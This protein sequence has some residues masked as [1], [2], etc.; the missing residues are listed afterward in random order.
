ML[1]QIS[2]RRTS[3]NDGMC[4]ALAANDDL[5]DSS[6]KINPP[7]SGVC[8]AIVVSLV[9]HAVST[10]PFCLQLGAEADRKHVTGQIYIQDLH[11]LTQSDEKGSIH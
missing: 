8:A 6:C 9:L 1:L 10:C 11:I 2:H 4:S 3:R 7:Y 5:F